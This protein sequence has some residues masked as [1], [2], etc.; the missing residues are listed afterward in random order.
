MQKG[1]PGKKHSGEFKQKVAGDMR[2]NILRQN[3]TAAKYGISRSMVQS[4]ER[5]YL[6]ESTEGLYTECRGRKLTGRP[7]KLDKKVEE[8]LISEVQRLRLTFSSAVSKRLS[9]IGSG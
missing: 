6:E 7:P 8:V 4:W 5:I 2:E 3:E 1:T 9:S